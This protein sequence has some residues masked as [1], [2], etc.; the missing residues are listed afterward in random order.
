MSGRWTSFVALGDSFTEGLDDV[1]ADGSVAGWADRV[2]EVLAGGGSDFRYANLAIR[3]LGLGRVVD[4][5][6]PAAVA[7][8]PDLVSIAAG[9]NDVLRPR[10]DAAATG[11]RMDRAVGAL[12][13]TGATVVVF[14]GFD[15]GPRLPFGA[16]LAA[17]A[18]AYNDVV[19]EAAHRHG[20]VLVDLWQMP[21]LAHP[22]LW[23]VDRL[24]LSSLGHE[25]V[26][27][28]V[29]SALGIDPPFTWPAVSEPMPPPSRVAARRSDLNWGRQYLLPWLGRRVA[30]RSS[31]D[32]RLPKRPALEPLNGASMPS[33]TTGRTET[34]GTEFAG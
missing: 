15:P 28:A 18:A 26:C 32:G 9:G 25:H 1:R 17:R 2:A 21:E 8:R 4:D 6:V 3:G 19:R 30:G 11:Q 16:A 20:A 33:E 22:R 24:H 34:A 27:G 7:M 10:F 13:A 14:A 29:L 5:Q 23:S 31:G 12:T